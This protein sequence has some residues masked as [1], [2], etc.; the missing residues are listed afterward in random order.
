MELL[1]PEC[2]GPL[3][4]SD[5]KT[6]RC[7]L[8]GGSY[9]I[10]FMRGQTTVEAP[11]PVASMTE[12]PS[13]PVI[14]PPPDTQ[15]NPYRSP[16]QEVQTCAKHPNVKT[17]MACARCGVSVCGTCGF[18][19]ADGTQM[20][21]DCVALVRVGSGAASNVP[22]G[23]NCTRHPD[24]QA[25]QYCRSCRAPVCGTCDFALPG[26]VHVC[27]DCVTKTNT[28]LSEKRKKSLNWAFA[29]AVL[30]SLG[31]VAFFIGAAGGAFDD[32]DDAQVLGTLFSLFTFIPSLVGT[33]LATSTLD[34]RLSNPAS[35]WVAIIWNAIVLTI[36]ILLSV[37]GLFMA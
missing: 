31:T 10:L 37:A 2:M 30:S 17:E 20:C 32:P 6:A 11:V 24:I 18:P 29:L 27:P 13:G 15:N 22:A 4:S 21:P 7:T 5:G 33:A 19:Q 16:T 25:V 8:H 12:A 34:R 9:R 23:V 26:G 1:C 36:F 14:G 35:V 28:G 3:V